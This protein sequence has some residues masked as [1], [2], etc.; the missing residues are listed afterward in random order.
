[1]NSYLDLEQKEVIGN[2][3]SILRIKMG[4]DVA[5]RW[6]DNMLDVQVFNDALRGAVYSESTKNIL[7]HGFSWQA[8]F[9]G[10]EYWTEVFLKGVSAN[11]L[12]TDDYF[13]RFSEWGRERK[14]DTGGTMSGQLAKLEEEVW[15]LFESVKNHDNTETRDAIGDIMV[16]LTMVCLIRGWSVTECLGKA[17]DDIKDRKGEMRDGIFHKEES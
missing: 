14:I 15:E 6:E 10:M 16:V 13:A 8:S 17:W 2:A 5:R 1:M 9:E 3:A 11:S 12:S 7:W 4:D